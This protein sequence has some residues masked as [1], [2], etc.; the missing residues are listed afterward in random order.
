MADVVLTMCVLVNMAGFTLTIIDEIVRNYI[1]PVSNQCAVKTGSG[2]ERR[3]RG[4]CL[5]D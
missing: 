2:C 3:R 1:F 5:F 4:E